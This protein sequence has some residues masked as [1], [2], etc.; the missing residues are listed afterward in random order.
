MVATKQ[1]PKKS[2]L[3]GLS[4]S[5]RSGDSIKIFPINTNDLKL[6]TKKASKRHKNWVK[7]NK[8]SAEEGSILI[9]PDEKGGIF[10]V[11]WGIL[12]STLPED[13]FEYAK[14]AQ[15]LPEGKYHFGKTFSKNTSFQV[16][17]GWSLAHYNFDTY[18][19]KGDK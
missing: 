15:G 6:W 9:L 14:L 18:K 3:R 19:T 2:S 8:F 17:L 12:G 10:E 4:F 7:A 16:A 11:L 1:K 5:P 13:H